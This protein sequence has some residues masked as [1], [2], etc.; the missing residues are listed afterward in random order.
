MEY[1]YL[2]AFLLTAR[3]QS[4]SL[5]AAELRIAQSAVSRQIKLLEESLGEQLI[6][7]SPK[8]VILTAKG[9]ELYLAVT[10][11]DKNA[12]ALFSDNV[13]PEVRIGLLHGVLETWLVSFVRAYFQ[14]HEL[15]L[16]LE[17][18]KPS[19]LIDG[20]SS[21]KF[22]MIIINEP[23]QNETVSSLKLFEEEM[24]F[25]AKK[26]IDFDKIET[27][28]WITYATVDTIHSLYKRKQSDRHI[29]VNSMTAIVNLVRADIGIAV[30]PTHL[31][32]ADEK[33]WRYPIPKSKNPSIYISTLNY[34]RMPK[35][36]AT[37]IHSLREL[38][39]QNPRANADADAN[40]V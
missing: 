5:A 21:R 9:Q 40:G 19:R 36:L 25:I 11:F 7:R 4:F 8:H 20:L 13:T 28:R 27:Y 29:R 10:D 12:E 14:K 24:V 26:K 15:N 17:V 30:V 16:F 23:V 38:A 2:K 35:H 34:A 31:L 33:L 22:D 1:K 18:D 6:V 3:H 39:A 32:A 37:L